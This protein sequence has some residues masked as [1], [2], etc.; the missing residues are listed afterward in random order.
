MI[1]RRVLFLILVVALGTSALVCASGGG[2]GTGTAAADSGAQ[3][4]APKLPAGYSEPGAGS[5]LAKVSVGMN[6]TEVRKILGDPDNAN[7][8]MTGKAFNPFYFGGDT[9]RTDWMYKGKGRVVFSRNRWSGALKVVRV[10]ANAN[11]L[12]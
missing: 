8:Y 11:E 4:A 3:A 5:D 7:A 9:H 1:A 12:Q 6:D 2:G 10:M